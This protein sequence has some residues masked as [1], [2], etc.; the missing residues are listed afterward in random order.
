MT[1]SD[2]ICSSVAEF[3]R[4]LVGCPNF[5]HSRVQR[6]G[7]LGRNEAL[8]VFGN[9][10]IQMGV[11]Q[12]HHFNIGQDQTS[13]IA[14][15][16]GQLDSGAMDGSPVFSDALLRCLPISAV[17]ANYRIEYFLSETHFRVAI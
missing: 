9:A 3:H 17:L 12:R 13:S 15:H 8:P 16:S 7:H 10:R 11:H 1:F 4:M 2:S 5:G 14:I 6:I